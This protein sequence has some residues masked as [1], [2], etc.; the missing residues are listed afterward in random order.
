MR[1]SYRTSRYL[2]LE[3]TMAVS[4]PRGAGAGA[5][6]AAAAAQAEAQRRAEEAARKAAEA[7]RKAA[8]EAAQKAASQQRQQ[9]QLHSEAQKLGE[10]LQSHKTEPKVAEE[11]RTADA[12]IET[13]EARSQ[14]DSAERAG[15]DIAR[16]VSEQEKRTSN[17]KKPAAQLKDA[18]TS[19]ALNRFKAK[20]DTQST[21]RQ[22]VATLEAKQ[23]QDK[24]SKEETPK[25]KAVETR[26]DAKRQLDEAQDAQ[27]SSKKQQQ[28]ANEADAKANRARDRQQQT[29]ERLDRAQERVDKLSGKSD[30]HTEG[31][32]FIKESQK[33][34]EARKKVDALEV[35]NQAQDRKA[36]SLEGTAHTEQREA[37]H[38]YNVAKK[39]T[40]Q[41]IQS[42]KDANA[43]ARSAGKKEAFKGV[44]EIRDTDDAGSLSDTQQKKIFGTKLNVRTEDAVN[45]DLDAAQEAADRGRPDEAAAILR[46]SAEQSDDPVFREQLIRQAKDDGVIDSI[47]RGIGTNNDLPGHVSPEQANN[48]IR[49]LSR[50]ADVLPGD[51]SI[52]VSDS[53]V[54]AQKHDFGVTQR[55]QGA[56]KANKNDPTV[57]RVGVNVINHPDISDQPRDMLKEANPDI[58][59][60]AQRPSG[61]SKANEALNVDGADDKRTKAE[62]DRIKVHNE[63]QKEADRL[64]KLD[65]KD[66]PKNT[67]IERKGDTVT[68]T[69]TDD[70]GHVLE[71]TQ[72]TRDGDKVTIDTTTYGKKGQAERNIVST[73]PT[74]TVV[75]QA[76]FD[77]KGTDQKNPPSIE[78]LKNSREKGVEVSEARTRIESGKLV[79]DR[80]VQSKDGGVSGSHTEY[81][82]QKGGK[83]IDDKLDDKFNKDEPISKIEAKSYNIPPP[84]SDQKPTYTRTQQF[85]Q[86]NVSATSEVSR[87]LKGDNIGS[88]PNVKDLD[89][90]RNANKDKEDFDGDEKNPKQWNLEISKGHKYESQ[91]FMEGHPELSVVTTR[92]VNGN[93]VHEKVKGKTLDPTGESGELKDVDL[94]TDV[95]YDD[96]GQI[97][98]QRQKG[99]APNGQELDQEYR[100]EVSRNKRGQLEINEITESRSG[101]T[102]YRQQTTTRKT[103][104]GWRLVEAN[105]FYHDPAGKEVY[106][107]IDEKGN[108]TVQYRGYP[109]DVT[110]KSEDDLK[111]LEPEDRKL[112]QASSDA[113]DIQTKLAHRSNAPGFTDGVDSGNP[114]APAKVP[115]ELEHIQ[116][117]AGTS[118][119]GLDSYTSRAGGT[120][121][122][123]SQQDLIGTR[124]V[125]GTTSSGIGLI[126][127]G[128]GFAQGIREGNFLSASQGLASVTGGAAGLAGTGYN[129][130]AGRSTPTSALESSHA[131]TAKF[132]GRVSTASGVVSSGLDI[133]GGIKAGDGYQV[134]KGGVGIASTIATATI[135]TSATG[136]AGVAIAV[137]IAG[138]TYV[139]NKFIDALADKEHDIG[140]VK[141]G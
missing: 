5:A 24:P 10:K 128:V 22:Q 37:D 26:R 4:G 16:E 81:T 105:N 71:R 102:S 68:V 93:H 64:L 87:P 104:D 23:Q 101:E 25:E 43:A 6:A 20:L 72:A 73:T 111:K 99:T 83:G 119:A 48:A 51:G 116:A 126:S 30:E 120:K 44:D 45:S 98:L 57:A 40:D 78:Q 76:K 127:G 39:E 123:P 9:E 140:D 7:A 12:R 113:V 95:T 62:E 117:G 96:N 38:D 1:A 141:I 53:L 75:Q 121:L 70:D 91:T 125:L 28:E 106:A 11:A 136:P 94:T 103:E 33:L 97:R 130:A 137:G 112:V 124:A 42:M 114:N 115:E 8:A 134:L 52:F 74:E 88:P 61:R 17:E 82:S 133:V 108:K 110:I 15:R 118:K 29:E 47:T 35:K 132:F 54:E 27:K 77:A 139:V 92:E 85:S 49:D 36:D 80:Y 19:N 32:A 46:E 65:P 59:A 138:G 66:E 107:K 129:Y 109:K 79:Q 3:D 84:G 2:F 55:L 89:Q 14:K 100:R 131:S 31:K 122:T 21:G 50:A 135:A 90:V 13:K 58:N 86:E 18:L 56:L 67:D 34:K 60:V 41:A 63:S 69:R